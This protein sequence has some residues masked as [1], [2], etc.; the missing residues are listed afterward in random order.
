MA[1]SVLSVYLIECLF[2]SSPTWKAL[3]NPSNPDSCLQTQVSVHSFRYSASDN[4]D[5][6]YGTHTKQQ[7]LGQIQ[8]EVLPTFHRSELKSVV[9]DG[10]WW[11]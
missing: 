10:K 1:Q 4:R 9:W 5:V 8:K 7:V 6:L 2:L 11:Q 3:T